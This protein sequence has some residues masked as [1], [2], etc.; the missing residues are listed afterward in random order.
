MSPTHFGAA[1]LEYPDLFP[2]RRA[3][4]LWGPH[5]IVLALPG[6]PYGFAGLAEVQ[7]DAVLDRL[8]AYT[9]E[10]SVEPAVTCH[11]FRAAPSD[12]V[13]ID[14]RGWEY[15][16]EFDYG[17][18]VVRVAGM[19]LM[20]LLE[21]TGSLEAALFSSVEDGER[22][23][24]AFENFLRILT[25]YRLVERGGALVHSA[26]VV[27]RGKAH[28]FPGRS[29]SGKST[30]SRLSVEAGCTVLSD[31][32]NAVT[33]RDGKTWVEKVP[34]SGDFKAQRDGASAYPLRAVFRLEKGEAN[35]LRALTRA[36]SLAALF[37]CAPTVNVDPHRRDALLSNLEQMTEHL[38]SYALTFT[39][40]R[41]VWDLVREHTG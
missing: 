35:A 3:G 39:R 5:R 32:L 20:G 41:S 10:D 29:G 8:Q 13:E 37:T 9:A 7:R 30:L 23:Y 33:L 1:Y 28:L 36:E 4:E 2:A 15:S 27:D 12:F 25:A 34:F 14:T 18:R 6:G 21:W 31:D 26:G 38:P 22:F 19:S 40:S 11:V 24:G 17:P 16:L